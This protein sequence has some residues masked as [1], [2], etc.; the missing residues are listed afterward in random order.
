MQLK[1]LTSSYHLNKQNGF[2]KKR[3]EKKKWESGLGPQRVSPPLLCKS[4][5]LEEENL[6]QYSMIN[7]HWKNSELQEQEKKIHIIYI[8]IYVCV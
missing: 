2:M 4:V 8:Y 6:I 7:I 3:E 1:R 5:V